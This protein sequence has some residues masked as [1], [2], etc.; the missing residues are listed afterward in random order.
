MGVRTY[1][2]G[3]LRYTNELLNRI[4]KFSVEVGWIKI[5]EN[6]IW[7]HQER[8]SISANLSSAKL[9]YSSAKW[10]ISVVKLDEIKK[11][12]KISLP[13]RLRDNVETKIATDR[14]N[15]DY[16]PKENQT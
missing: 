1:C 14:Q 5:Y 15:F 6:E 13:S 16:I 11:V 9:H 8:G 7:I 4:R 12:S 3:S 2:F 10:N